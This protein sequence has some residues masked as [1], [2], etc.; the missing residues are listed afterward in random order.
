MVYDP[1]CDGLVMKLSDASG[2]AHIASVEPDAMDNAVVSTA[3]DGTVTVTGAM[4][5]VTVSVG[6]AA[7]YGDA[8]KYSF[9]LLVSDDKAHKASAKVAYEVE[10]VNRAPIAAEGTEVTVDEGKIS[11]VL[12]YASLFT[13]PDGDDMT[14]VFEM[15][16]NDFAEAFTTGRSVVFQ[17]KARG[18]IVA[19]VTA[20]DAAGLS[21]TADITVTVK[22]YSGIDDIDA[23]GDALVRL[24]ENPVI[25][26][27]KL[28]S[29]VSDKISI[30]VF[31]AAG[32][33][34]YSTDATV[35]A[36]QIFDVDCSVSGGVYI[37]RVSNAQK[38][39]THRFVKK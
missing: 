32:T 31:D 17:G 22:E 15:P 26:T 4:A 5:A 33:L 12:E 35:S 1:D 3:D 8:G 10:H 6:I 2:L 29:L 36:G 27:L 13:D 30:E 38:A 37:L 24:V 9:T 20:T 23:A 39:E 7:E 16:A 18:S 14:Y 11:D 28:Q 19:K 21:T 25:N 34:R